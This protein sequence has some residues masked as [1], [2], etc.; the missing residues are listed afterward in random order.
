MNDEPKWNLSNPGKLSNKQATDFLHFWQQ[1]V[2]SVPE[3]QAWSPHMAFNWE[4]EI[5]RW[6]LNE[7][8]VLLVLGFTYAFT[9]QRLN[10]RQG[11]AHTFLL[12]PMFN[13]IVFHGKLH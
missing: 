4:S 11:A 1:W 12:I 8:S 2:S 7:S 5:L 3:K 13:V 6:L 10:Q 9:G